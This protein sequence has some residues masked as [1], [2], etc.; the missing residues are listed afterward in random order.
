MVQISDPAEGDWVM[1]GSEAETGME[2]GAEGKKTVGLLASGTPRGG[3][4]GNIGFLQSQREEA[5][6]RSGHGLRR[7]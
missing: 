7:T 6:L 1:C 2:P 5:G 3:A 4:N